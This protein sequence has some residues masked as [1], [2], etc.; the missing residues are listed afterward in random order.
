MK[1]RRTY[2]PDLVD[3]ALSATVRMLLRGKAVVWQGSRMYRT[4]QGIVLDGVLI[5]NLV[6]AVILW[7]DRN[8]PA[9][10]RGSGWFLEP[11]KLD[12]LRRRC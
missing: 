4:S 5:D 3:V 7:F 9:D 2:P 11:G 12:E 1:R 8:S 6:D 10:P